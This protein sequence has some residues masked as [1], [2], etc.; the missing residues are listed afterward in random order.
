MVNHELFATLTSRYGNENQVAGALQRGFLVRDSPTAWVVICARLF[1]MQPFVGLAAAAAVAYAALTRKTAALVPVIV[2]GPVLAFAAWGQYTST[3]FG[4]FRFYLLAIPLVVCVAMAFWTPTDRLRPPW[5]LETRANKLAALLVC[6]SILIG[7]PVTVRAELNDHIDTSPVQFGLNSLVRPQRFPA[8]EQWYR[9]MMVNDRLLADYL[10]RQQLPR[11]SV[12]MDTAYAWGVWVSS[13]DPKQ[14]V[15][16]SDYDFRAA[17]NR[18]WQY[19]VKY[20]LVSNPSF[21]DADAINIRYPTLWNDGAGFSRQ[22][23]TMMTGTDDERFR[24]Y[25]VTGAPKGPTTP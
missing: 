24:L 7:F 23:Y 9:Q 15:V 2:F 11:G 19:D 22:V 5:T 18:P 13:D 16:N 14:F 12:L 25:E 8:E 20:L 21:T 6:A 4:W 1:G 3:T 10:D 17:L